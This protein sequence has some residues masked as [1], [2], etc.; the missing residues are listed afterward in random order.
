MK[1]FHLI[2]G[3]LLSVA[4]ASVASP[5]PALEAP[6][7]AVSGS[8]A[9]RSWQP[10]EAQRERVLRD[11]L[12]YFAAKDEGRYGDAYSR[13]SQTQK[14]TVSFERW[15]GH[16]ERF[17]GEA[18]TLES[19]SIR[20]VT[21]YSNAANAPAGVYAA[22]DFT[23]VFS[24]LSLYCGYVALQQQTDGSFAVAREEE[25]SIPKAAMAKLSPEALQ[26]VRAEFRC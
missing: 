17:Y 14:A 19:R 3:L 22:V 9:D 2:P 4:L 18:G 5:S 1:P 25:N 20:K 23:G 11:V 13:F 10:T 26:R 7:H 6:L 21:W 24:G 12:A 16:L 8:N 15:K